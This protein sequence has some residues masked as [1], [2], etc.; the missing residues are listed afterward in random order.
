MPCGLMARA[1]WRSWRA[2]QGLWA[3]LGPP[4]L[5]PLGTEE[6][7]ATA[8]RGTGLQG[9]G[10]S[11]AIWADATQKETVLQQ[12]FLQHRKQDRRDERHLSVCNKKKPQEL[13]GWP[14][15]PRLPRWDRR[16][17]AA[18]LAL[19]VQPM[20]VAVLPLGS[21]RLKDVSQGWPCRVRSGAVPS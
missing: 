5:E 19:F 12:V 9:S 6:P 10:W 14:R 4:G 15:A 11:G 17:P 1:V 3:S 16:L 7:G 21:Q 2:Q 18:D 8:L 13:T 20:Q